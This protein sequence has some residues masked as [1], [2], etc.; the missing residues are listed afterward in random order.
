MSATRAYGQVVARFS[1]IVSFGIVT[2]GDGSTAKR[3]LNPNLWFNNVELIMAEKI[4]R[5]TVQYVSNMYE[6]YL[7]HKTPI[8]QRDERLK[9]KSAVVGKL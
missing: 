3:G 4:R 5:E 1:R 9:A 6:Y 2:I 7:A 8:E